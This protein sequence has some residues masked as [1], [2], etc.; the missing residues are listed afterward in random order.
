MYSS[1]T[2]IFGNRGQTSYSAANDFLNSFANYQRYVCGKPCLSVCWGAMGGAGMLDRN[3][4]VALIL[5]SAGFYKLDID[6]GICYIACIYIFSLRQTGMH[7]LLLTKMSNLKV[8]MEGPGFL[9]Y[10]AGVFFQF[11]CIKSLVDFNLD[12]K[13]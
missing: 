8:R 3:A 13:C 1:A 2:S 4:S 6:Q 7:K 10:E 11:L 5:E 12:S 9:T